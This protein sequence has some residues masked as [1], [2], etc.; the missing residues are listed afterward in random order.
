RPNYSLQYVENTLKLAGNSTVH[1]YGATFYATYYTPFG[2]SIN[3]D[4]AYSATSGYSQGYDTKQWMWNANLAYSFLRNKSATVSLR[5]YDLLQQ[6]SNISRN[7]TANYIDDSLYNS[8]T[9]YFMVSFTYK[10]NTF[11]KGHEPT[12]RNARRF[13]GPGGGPMGPPPG[14]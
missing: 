5:V 7:V 13:G 9:R 6:K 11:G 14:R 2:L 1:G 10:F 3:T 12:D 4:V 8:L